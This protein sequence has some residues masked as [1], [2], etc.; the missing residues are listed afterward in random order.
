MAGVAVFGYL[1]VV[2]FPNEDASVTDSS[3]GLEKGLEDDEELALWL[4]PPKR[5]PLNNELLAE[6]GPNGLLIMGAEGAAVVALCDD[7]GE[8]KY[9]EGTVVVG[10]GC[11][12]GWDTV[13]E[14]GVAVGVEACDDV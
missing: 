8:A 12:D 4:P 11:A 2:P 10:C 1:I 5:D 3:S 14:L 6:G 7:G 13:A 9:G